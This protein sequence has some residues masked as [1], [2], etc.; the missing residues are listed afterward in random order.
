MVSRWGNFRIAFRDLNFFHDWILFRIFL[1]VLFCFRWN[2]KAFKKIEEIH[3]RISRYVQA[4]LKHFICHFF[5]PYFALIRDYRSI[6]VSLRKITKFARTGTF[7]TVG[8]WIAIYNAIN[9]NDKSSLAIVDIVTIL[10]NRNLSTKNLPTC[11]S[12][13]TFVI[14]VLQ[15]ENPPT[16]R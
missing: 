12:W 1:K 7:K 5:H 2:L 16:S 15:K 6:S 13:E 3:S 4:Y 10:S 11:S 8:S 14:T 9:F